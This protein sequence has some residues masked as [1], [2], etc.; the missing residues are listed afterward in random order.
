M[1][2]I[3]G[4]LAV[5]TGPRSGVEIDEETLRYLPIDKHGLGRGFG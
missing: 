2:V 5:D 1:G 4:G 3:R